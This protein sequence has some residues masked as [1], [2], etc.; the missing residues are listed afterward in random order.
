MKKIIILFTILTSQLSV[1]QFGPVV[2]DLLVEGN[3]NLYDLTKYDEN[4]KGSP[5]LTEK[6]ESG[7]II[8]KN[9]KQY[10]A[11]IRLNISEQKFEI[12]NSNSNQ[13]SA[14]DINESVTISIRDKT[15]NLYSFK[16]NGSTN[17]IGILEDVLKLENYELYYFPQKKV[18]MPIV[19]GISAPASGY[20][21]TPRAEWKD[22]S[23]FLIFYNDQTYI[24]PTSHK[25]MKALNLLDAKAYKKYRK[26]NKLNLKNKESLKNF[27]TY[28]N[29]TNS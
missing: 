13:T 24:V 9:G 3:V 19:S 20:T 12:K 28:L 4:V 18:E 21:K 15:Y 23:V 7:K 6:F 5:Y 25:K 1:S 26:A 11:Q 16:M 10:N 2:S 8:F 29:S 17:T 27:V 22:S 14:I